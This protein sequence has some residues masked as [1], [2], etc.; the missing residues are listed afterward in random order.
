MNLKKIIDRM[1]FVGDRGGVFE[2]DSMQSKTFRKNLRKVDSALDVILANLIL[3][4][5]KLGNRRIDQLI[6]KEEFL[7]SIKYLDLDTKDKI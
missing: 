7:S 5:Y 4:S 3:F 1:A 6:N 2:Y